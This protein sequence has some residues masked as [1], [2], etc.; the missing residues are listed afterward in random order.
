MCSTRRLANVAEVVGDP[1]P[2]DQ[3][4]TDVGE[5]E[6]DHARSVT[7]QARLL[8]MDAITP[9][10]VVPMI[11]LDRVGKTYP[12]GSVAVGELSLEIPRDEICILVGP[13]GCGKTTTLQMINRLVEP[14]SRPDL[15]RR[16]RRHRRRPRRAPP[17]N[18]LRDPAGRAVPPPDDR[19]RTSRPSRACWAG[20]RT[21]SRRG[22]TSCS[23]SSASPR[24][25]TA[26]VPA[27]LS[28]GQ[29]QRVGVARALARRPAGAAHGR[30]VRRHRPRHPDAAPGRV[31]PAP[32][33]GAQDRGVRHP[34]HRGGGQDGRPDRHPRRR[35]RARAVRH[36]GRGAR[37]GPRPTWSPTS[38]APTG[39]SSACGSP[40]STPTSSSTRPRWRRTSRSP[41]RA[42]RWCAA[43]CTARR[44]RRRRRPFARFGHA[45]PR[46]RR[47]SRFGTPRSDR[48]VGAG[49]RQ[50]AGMRWRR[51]CSPR[52][53]GWRWSTA[54]GSWARSR[55][56]RCTG[57]CVVRLPNHLHSS[58]KW[59]GRVDRRCGHAPH[60]QGR[61]RWRWPT[62]CST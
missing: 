20:R 40:R 53:D 38:S 47:G 45:R 27:Q 46:R 30:A 60:A 54:P 7:G 32:G 19:P 35:R 44:G 9:Q 8:L 26:P 39:R 12:D 4:R 59:T 6:A 43:R 48:S 2:V 13:S 1:R 31:P 50:L 10:A 33:R 18:R 62:R 58:R 3:P 28:G 17:A 51:C 34:R 36:A 22:S 23:S 37:P 15:P 11:R 57:R 5:D 42:R 41:T 52:R 55:P 56:S 14:T 61:R 49:R 16:E 25:S 24:R 21:A 29:R